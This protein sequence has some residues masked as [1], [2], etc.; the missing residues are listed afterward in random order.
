MRFRPPSAVTSNPSLASLGVDLTSVNKED[1]FFTNNGNVYSSPP[2]SPDISVF[3][4]ELE[5]LV[6]GS[7]TTQCSDSMHSSGNLI[8]SDLERTGS[9]NN[10]GYIHETSHSSLRNNMALNVHGRIVGQNS[11]GSGRAKRKANNNS[12]PTYPQKRP[13]SNKQRG[14]PQS[15]NG[16]IHQK[17]P[18]SSH[19]DTLESDKARTEISPH[20]N[21]SSSVSNTSEQLNRDDKFVFL[22]DTIHKQIHLILPEFISFVGWCKRRVDFP[23]DGRIALIETLK[24][25]SERT[26]FS[27]CSYA[28]IRRSLIDLRLECRKVILSFLKGIDFGRMPGIY[29]TILHAEYKRFTGKTACIS[30]IDCF[31][32]IFF[33]TEPPELVILFHAGERKTGSLINVL[34]DGKYSIPDVFWNT[35]K[36]PGRRKIMQ[37]GYKRLL[38]IARENKDFKGVISSKFWYLGNIING[39]KWT[40]SRRNEGGAYNVKDTCHKMVENVAEL[41]KGF[42]DLI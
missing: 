19:G 33:V 21:P 5:D 36:S 39:E 8:A 20:L 17:S 4:S 13:P 23:D 34:S 22:V 2:H 6:E 32:R 12:N 9:S 35:S 38:S 16:H 11:I 14:L 27:G 26:I 7:S 29:E 42:L 1:L 24:T 31:M 37:D 15:I 28:D 10:A 41:G 18:T 25:M 30:Y 3:P 40:C